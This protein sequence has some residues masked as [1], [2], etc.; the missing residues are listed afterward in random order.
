MISQ[1]MPITIPRLTTA[2]AAIWLCSLALAL[3]SPVSWDVAWRLELADRMLD[4]Q[5]L[6]RDMVEV[7]PPL[8]FWSALPSTI[9][10][11]F[12]G[13]SAY[14]I[15]C[16]FNHLVVAGAMV[17]VHNCA[18][19][20]MSEKE[21]DWLIGGALV[22]LLLIPM[23]ELGQREQ[24]VLL[25]TLL[26]GILAIRRSQNIETH[27]L[28]IGIIALLSAYGFALKHYYVIVPIG[29][30]L[31]LAFQLKRSWR[32]FRLETVILGGAAVAYGAAV[33]A[34]APQ[35]LT[36]MVPLVALSYGEVRST[37]TANPLLH[38]LSMVLQSAL[39]ILPA[40]LLRHDLKTNPILQVLFL[41]IL[42]HVAV[43]FTQGKGFSNHFLAAKG[44]AFILWS[45][46]CAHIVKGNQGPPISPKIVTGVLFL[47]WVIMPTSLY[48]VVNR[49][50][51]KPSPEAIA[52]ATPLTGQDIIVQTIAT[53]PETARI[54]VVSTHPGLSFHYQWSLGR[55]HYARYFA[56][57]M[58]AGLKESQT[59]PDKREAA[60]REMD[61]VRANTITDIM[62]AKP[63]ILIG[64]TTTHGRRTEEGF[65]TYEMRPMELVL[66]DK[67][68]RA[69][70]SSRYTQTPEDKGVTIWR[71]KAD[72]R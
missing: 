10:G 57:W 45:V 6:Y 11:K 30:E 72:V 25:A 37:A 9:V 47:G 17:L 43:I 50:F 69:W 35:F 28:I 40:Y 39:L 26:W 16:L 70:L 24:P 52:S 4:G 59:K 29:I 1:T 22:A 15:L 68:F 64:D 36:D 54:F 49:P 19:P 12:T 34:F 60:T 21:R 41:A 46:A 55:P 61:K 8:W 5:V 62:R 2:F 20:I 65:S 33:V 66:E 71:L 56:M 3:I 7:N 13:L 51:T 23:F 53:A 48:L 38:P 63:D 42:L 18:K 27:P 14:T 67:A 31:W 58:I 32:P 44:F